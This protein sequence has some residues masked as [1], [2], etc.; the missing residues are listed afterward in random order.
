MGGGDEKGILEHWGPQTELGGEG[1]N[2][3]RK[4]LTPSLSLPSN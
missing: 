4:R 1:M 3:D 2:R